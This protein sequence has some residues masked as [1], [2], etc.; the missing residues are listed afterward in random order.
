VDEVFPL[1]DHADYPE[2]LETVAQ[3]QPRRVLTVHGYT[4]EFAADLRR[5][6]YEAWALAQDDQ[7]ELAGL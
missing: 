4:R 2:L 1:S 3:V 6:G 5:R 7:L